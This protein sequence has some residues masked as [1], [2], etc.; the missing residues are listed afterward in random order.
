MNLNIC[1]VRM[2]IY[3]M[4]I[5]YWAS[6]VVSYPSS[7]LV[8]SK[9][10]LSRLS[11]HHASLGSGVQWRVTLYALHFFPGAFAYPHQPISWPHRLLQGSAPLTSLPSREQY[12]LSFFTSPRNDGK[13]SVKCLLEMKRERCQ[14]QGTMGDALFIGIFNSDILYADAHHLLSI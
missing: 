7:P 14:L 3:H 10:L 8:E 5:T 11:K 2:K 9:W 6:T 12:C 1:T 13:K 4:F